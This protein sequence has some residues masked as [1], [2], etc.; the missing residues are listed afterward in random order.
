LLLTISNDPFKV[1]FRAFE[2]F[3]PDKQAFVQFDQTLNKRKKEYGYTHF[4]TGLIDMPIVGIN[5][6]LTVEDSIEILA[7]EL[8]HVAVGYE[9]DHN[10]E[11][12]IVFKKIV[13]RTKEIFI[14]DFSPIK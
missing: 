13:D 2:E 14:E 4:D 5:P 12:E 3:Y 6:K 11:F 9:A 1:V 8:A 10:E 7:H